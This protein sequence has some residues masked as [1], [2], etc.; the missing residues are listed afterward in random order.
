MGDHAGGAGP[1]VV[2]LASSVH[3]P[4]SS[5]LREQRCRNL[6]LE[7]SPSFSGQKHHSPPVASSSNFP[8]LTSVAE[9]D[10]DDLEALRQREI[11]HHRQHQLRKLERHRQRP[12]S[13]AT[14][15]SSGSAFIAK[16]T[17]PSS[18]TAA[19]HQA[20]YSHNIS[21]HDTSL[22]R[23]ISSPGSV[24]FSTSSG[25]STQ[26]A[27]TSVHRYTEYKPGKASS[28]RAVAS[29]GRGRS[30]MEDSD[31]TN[32]EH[33]EAAQDVLIW[34]P[35]SPASGAA[36]R[37]PVPQRDLPLPH[38]QL[39]RSPPSTN[40]SIDAG[41]SGKRAGLTPCWRKEKQ[42]KDVESSKKTSATPMMMGTWRRGAV[43]LKENGQFY[44]FGEVSRENIG[45]RPVRSSTMRLPAL[46][47]SSV[48]FADACT[49]TSYVGNSAQG[50][51]YSARGSQP[52]SAIQCPRYLRAAS[53]DR[54]YVSRL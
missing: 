49:A 16:F 20:H 52:T 47:Y 32:H 4:S 53:R 10:D 19:S 3:R 34:I 17:R 1:K 31:S 6:P 38:G 29:T 42:G 23:Q 2:H 51:G 24:S 30:Q 50:H 37:S 28:S 22:A 46:A 26:S 12:S 21:N 25:G 5:A 9:P 11:F 15:R 18:R 40:A 35:E 48:R 14:I 8:P 13:A 54:R 41:N 33:L 45:G 44:I 43:S 7:K 39:S 27:Y 36:L